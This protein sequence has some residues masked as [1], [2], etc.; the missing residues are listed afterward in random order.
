MQY[1]LFMLTQILQKQILNFS[2]LFQNIKNFF[3]IL[4]NNI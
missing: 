2:H 1:I 4:E 3:Y